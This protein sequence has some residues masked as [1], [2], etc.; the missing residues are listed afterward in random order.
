MQNEVVVR[1]KQPS[2][3]ALDGYSEVNLSHSLETRE[4]IEPKEMTQRRKNLKIIQRK[5]F[6]F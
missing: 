3:Q 2:F 6:A 4:R 5:F 1:S